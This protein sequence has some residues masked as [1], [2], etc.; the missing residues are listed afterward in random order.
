MSNKIKA[1]YWAYLDWEKAGN[2][3][4]DNDVDEI[5]S[6]GFALSGYWLFKSERKRKYNLLNYIAGEL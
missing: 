3:T 4:L 1:L 5:L 2:E 6:D